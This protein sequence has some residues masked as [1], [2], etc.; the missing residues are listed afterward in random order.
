MSPNNHECYEFGPF[1]LDAVQRVLTRHG[2][3][4]SLPPKTMEILLMLVR[5]PGQ[6]IGKEELMSQVWPDAFVEHVALR[7]ERE[8]RWYVCDRDECV[9]CGGVAGVLSAGA[10]RDEGRSAHGA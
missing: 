6:L 2:Q 3:A 5:R 1:R 7:G 4:I 9:V 10:S 8:R